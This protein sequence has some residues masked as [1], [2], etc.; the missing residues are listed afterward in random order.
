MALIEGADRTL[1][2]HAWCRHLA[3]RLV[4]E[5]AVAE[6]WGE[7][8]PLLRDA[9]AFFDDGGDDAIASAC[10][11]LLRRAGAKVPRRREDPRVPGELRALGVTARELEVLHLLGQGLPNNDIGARLYLSPRTVERHVASLAAKIGAERRS[12]LV[13]YAARAVATDTPAP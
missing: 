11:S 1:T 12:A 13:A 5:A 10:R 7:P 8:V 3:R 2:H 9:L 6:G 4:A